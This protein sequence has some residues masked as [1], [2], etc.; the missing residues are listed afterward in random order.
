MKRPHHD[1]INVYVA[2]SDQTTE[3]GRTYTR[4]DHY[5]QKGEDG[6]MMPLSGEKKIKEIL[7]DCPLSVEMISISNSEIRKAIRN[8]PNFLNSVFDVYN[9]DCKPLK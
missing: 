9:N 7:Q 4:A 2:F 6:P 5:A 3:S 8:S 1:K